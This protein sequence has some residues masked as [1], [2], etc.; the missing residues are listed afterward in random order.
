M[1]DVIMTSLKD[2]ASFFVKLC[3][4]KHVWNLNTDPTSGWSIYFGMKK[5]SSTKT[6]MHNTI[7]MYQRLN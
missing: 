4:D 5:A 3:I 6:D 7:E 1:I 2:K